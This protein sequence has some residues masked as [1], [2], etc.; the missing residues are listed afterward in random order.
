MGI[1][2]MDRL[3]APPLYCI[4]T[5]MQT[6]HNLQLN[7]L[8]IRLF[9]NSVVLIFGSKFSCNYFTFIKHWWKLQTAFETYFPRKVVYVTIV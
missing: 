4:L 1:R 7:G 8:R 2:K 3:W 9:F 6:T 5:D